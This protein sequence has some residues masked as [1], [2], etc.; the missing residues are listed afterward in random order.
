MICPECGARNKPEARRCRECGE[1]LVETGVTGKAPAP[2]RRNDEEDEERPRKRR[3]GVD[4]DDEEGVRRKLKKLTRSEDDELP[5]PEDTAAAALI[6]LGVSPW[7]L[8]AFYLGLIG[9]VPL[10]GAPLGLLAIVCGI[11]ALVRRPKKSSYGAVTGTARAIIGLICG[12]LSIGV[13]LLIL[14]IGLVNRRW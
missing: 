5:R 9:C 4:A 6:P 12:V 10:F 14:V 13:A 8:A 11:M 3:A 7:A 2:R 1:D